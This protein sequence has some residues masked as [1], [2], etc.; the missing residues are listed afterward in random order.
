MLAAYIEELGSPDLI[1][2]G[3]LPPPQPGPGDVL[4]DVE[5]TAVNHVDTFVRSGAWRTPMSFPF[6]IGRDLA[7]TVV[8]AGPGAPGFRA[9]DRVW[10]SSLGH[11]GRQGAAAER[12]VVPADRLYHLPDGVDA[13]DAVALSHPASTAYLALFTHGRVRAGETVLVLGAAGNVGSAAVVM[14]A[15][16][17]ARV[18]AVAS[19]RDAD[20]CRALGARSVI[21]YRDPEASWWIGEAAPGGVDLYIDTSG[22]NDLETAMGLLAPRGRVVILAGL[23]TRPVLP[24]GPLYLQ[25]RSVHGFAISHAR[26]DELAEAAAHIGRL[27]SD[28]LLRPRATE[29]LPLSEAAKAHR[30]LEESKVHGKLVLRVADPAR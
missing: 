21:D 28:G 16:A 13:V 5:V 8:A 14:A 23:R 29:V 24:A 15:Q 9:G 4:V 20:Y 3:D 30:R 12:V 26:A 18:V 27:M 7:G 1:Q 17:G 11:A 10:C 19:A 6:V 2:V 22:R 25:D